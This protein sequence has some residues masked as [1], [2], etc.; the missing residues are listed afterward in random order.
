MT[1]LLKKK[2]LILYRLCRTGAGGF[3]RIKPMFTDTRSTELLRRVA[4][5]VIESG[6]PVQKNHEV[7]QP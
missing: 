5:G 3:V 2:E 4:Q 7:S 6:V 1:L